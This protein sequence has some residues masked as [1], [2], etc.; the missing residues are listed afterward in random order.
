[1]M[2]GKEVSASLLPRRWKKSLD[3][4]IIIQ[5][6]KIFCNECKDKKTSNSCNYQINET[7]EFEAKLNEIKRHPPNEVGYMLSFL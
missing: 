7:K 4:G 3:S 6:K 5:E 1:M 2:E